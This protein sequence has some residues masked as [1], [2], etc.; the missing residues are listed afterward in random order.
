[1]TKNKELNLKIA[2]NVRKYRNLKGISHEDLEVLA[3]I[4]YDTII[5]IETGKLEEVSIQDIE[6]IAEALD[7]NIDD[8]MEI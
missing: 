5:Q 7:A 1:M 6:A 2:Q 4:D 8:I 3:G